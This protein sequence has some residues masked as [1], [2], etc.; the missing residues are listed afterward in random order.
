MN[1]KSI[2]VSMVIVALAFAV[3]QRVPAIRQPLLGY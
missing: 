2:V 1:V 3:V